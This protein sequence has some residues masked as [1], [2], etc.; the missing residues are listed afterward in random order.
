MLAVDDGL[1]NT[2]KSGRQEKKG[3]ENETGEKWNSRVK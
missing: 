1:K 3:R 2:S